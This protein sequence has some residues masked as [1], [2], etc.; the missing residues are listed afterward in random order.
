MTDK[1]LFRRTRIAGTQ[2]EHR[3][4]QGQSRDRVLQATRELQRA[5]VH[6]PR[7]IDK[8]RVWDVGML[9]AKLRQCG[10]RRRAEEG[11]PRADWRTR[12]CGGEA[13]Q[14]PGKMRE[15]VLAG[16]G[17]CGAKMWD[18]PVDTFGVGTGLAMQGSY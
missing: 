11:I 6:K 2:G 16:A 5:K 17:A 18:I 10:C 13:A 1:W 12:L 7:K 3:G 15:G 4:S 9:H 8:G 14:Y